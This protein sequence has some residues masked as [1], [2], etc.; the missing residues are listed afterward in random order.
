MKITI[1]TK[2]QPYIFLDVDYFEVEAKGLAAEGKNDKGSQIFI[3][4]EDENN[5]DN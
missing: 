4:K 3:F 1:V 5:G 2:D